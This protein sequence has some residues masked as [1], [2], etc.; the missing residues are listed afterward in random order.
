[1]EPRGEMTCCCGGVPV[2]GDSAEDDMIE[3][4]VSNT[5]RAPVPSTGGASKLL[6]RNEI[7]NAYDCKIDEK[8]GYFG[9]K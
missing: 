1:M 2:G 9:T 8:S 3:A 7:F 5:G 4:D 6:H